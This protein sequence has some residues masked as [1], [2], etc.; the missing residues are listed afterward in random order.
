M[1]ASVGLAVPGAA[2]PNGEVPQAT[3]VALLTGAGSINETDVRYQVSG[4]DLGIMW[5]DKRG[6]VLLAFGDTF[7]TGWTGSDPVSGSPTELDWRSNTLARSSDHDPSDGLSF[8]DFITDYPGHA[9]ELVPSLK[10]DHV[11]MTT[12]PTGGVNI[13]GRNYMAYMSVRHYGP[14]AGQWTTNYSAIAY[15]DDD[16][17]TWVQAPGTRRLNTPDFDDHFQMIAYAQQDRFVY[18]F[19]TSNGRFG[20]AYLA[21]V[22][23]QKLLDQAAYEYWSD[24][25]WKRG[26][27]V[28]AAPIVPGPVGELSICFNETLH[29]WM[30][31]YL[32][33][34]R[35]AI[36]VRLAPQ[37]AG[38][39][40]PPITVATAEKYPTLYGGFFHPA[41][42]STEI[43]FTMTQPV[44]CRADA[45]RTATRRAEGR[46]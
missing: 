16:G 6:Q 28:I 8:Y 41:S 3:R 29:R 33:E 15:S 12:I 36:V 27:S 18:A 23:E 11:E 19:G 22:P 4:T 24:S 42:N 7:G 2:Q 14:G 13:S 43:Y 25:G 17:Q 5:N 1:A 34:S 30:M 40:S 37:P 26:D 46:A 21:R 20:S 35:A 38:P 44:Q 10:Q 45:G 32:D 31:M 9:K 39:W